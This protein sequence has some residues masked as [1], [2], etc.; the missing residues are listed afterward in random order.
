MTTSA[1]PPPSCEASDRWARI[2]RGWR[3][4]L[5]R[6][7]YLKLFTCDHPRSTVETACWRQ[8]NLSSSSSTRTHRPAISGYL[9]WIL[10]LLITYGCAGFGTAA[11]FWTSLGVDKLVVHISPPGRL[12]SRVLKAR[13]QNIWQ[14]S[15]PSRMEP[16][17]LPKNRL[18]STSS[19]LE[20][21]HGSWSYP[22]GPWLSHIVAL[23][24]SLL[25]HHDNFKVELQL[26]P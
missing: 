1:L 10:S 20:N 8:T 3:L 11:V 22:R 24:Q 2:R 15:N 26:L 23:H 14:Q 19:N 4:A 7:S 17:P 21:S 18:L 12:R 13:F 16:P 6:C 25:V 5:L 9:R